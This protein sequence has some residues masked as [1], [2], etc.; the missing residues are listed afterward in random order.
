MLTPW[1]RNGKGQ[2]VVPELNATGVL[3]LMYKVI[4]FH[5]KYIFN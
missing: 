4:M 1:E 2:G 5:G 3:V